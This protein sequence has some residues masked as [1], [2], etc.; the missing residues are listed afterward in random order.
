MSSKGGGA[1]LADAAKAV[2]DLIAPGAKLGLDLL[3]SIRLPSPS[4]GCGCEIPPPCWAPQPLGDFTTDACPG[5]KAV[6]RLTITNCGLTGRTIKVSATNKAVKVEPASLPLGP[7]GDGLV[8]LS[9]EV[10]V[11]ATKGQTQ[12]SLVWIHGCQEHYLRWTVE[13][14]SLGVSCCA[15]EIELEDCPDL[16]HHWYDHFYC[17]RPCP[18]QD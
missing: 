7:M 3:G 12:K 5:D 8:A 10:P 1:T 11:G 4:R 13:V 14:A 17:D 15:T 18:N 16:I 9:L 6:L 2:G